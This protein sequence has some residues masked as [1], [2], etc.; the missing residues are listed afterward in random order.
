MFAGPA[1][2]GLAPGGAAAALQQQMQEVVAELAQSCA[3]RDYEA[4]ISL[5]ALGRDVRAL[6]T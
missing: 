3:E 6:H 4:A 1:R 2:R 5:L